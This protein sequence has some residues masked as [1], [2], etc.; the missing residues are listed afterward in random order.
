[1]LSHANLDAQVKCLNAAWNIQSTDTILH[2][3]PLN[4]VH[5]LINA[6]QTLFYAGGKVVMM[7]KYETQKVFSR[8]LNIN[9]PQKDRI[10]LYMGVPTIYSLLIQEYDK[11]F[12]KDSQICEYIKTHC[13]SKVRLMVSG[14]AP[15]PTTGETIKIFLGDQTSLYK[16]FFHSFPPLA[17]DHRSQFA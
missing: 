13:Q 6:L 5:G 12:K 8:L 16:T 3:L 11:S 4:H 10:T 1:M 2:T 9:L 7:P 15:L 17:R 14:S